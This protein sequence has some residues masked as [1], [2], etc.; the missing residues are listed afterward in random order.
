MPS[1]FISR[2]EGAKVWLQRQ[3]HVIDHL[4][5]H[6]DPQQVQPGD[7]VYGT[8]PIHLA[9]QVCARGAEYHHLLL[10]MPAEARGRELS[11]DELELYG[12]RLV[13]YECR[14]VASRIAGD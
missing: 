9:A 1:W 8:L 10:E 4:C 11:A 5:E 13:Q 6:L 3:G 14:A 12:A 7:R 2:H